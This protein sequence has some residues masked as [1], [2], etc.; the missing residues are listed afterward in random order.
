[1]TAA[2]GGQGWPGLLGRPL[3]ATTAIDPA[4][5][6]HKIQI[7]AP[8]NTPVNSRANCAA[9]RWYRLEE[10]SSENCGLAEWSSV[11]LVTWRWR[12]GDCETVVKGVMV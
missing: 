8:Q 1:M 12:M 11:Q 10:N 9:I 3:Q 6:S 7:Q 5:S 4:W 2:Q